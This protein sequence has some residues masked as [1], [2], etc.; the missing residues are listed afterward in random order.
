MNQSSVIKIES[1][2]SLKRLPSSNS[3][4]FITSNDQQNASVRARSDKNEINFSKKETL[5]ENNKL[6]NELVSKKNEF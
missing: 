5:D 6:R 1:L 3:I 4:A 2:E